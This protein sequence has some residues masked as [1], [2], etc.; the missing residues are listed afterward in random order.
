MRGAA[1]FG[2]RPPYV[3]IPSCIDISIVFTHV[4]AYII[5]RELFV[6]MLILIILRI[7]RIPRILRIQ[8]Y[9]LI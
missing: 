9:C 1:A 5:E 3:W 6:L 7:L 2:R 4:S 8:E